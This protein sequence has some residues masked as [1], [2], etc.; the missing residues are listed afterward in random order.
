MIKEF[1]QWTGESPDEAYAIL[2]ICDKCGYE[3]WQ[4]ARTRTAVN[5]KL[6]AEGW[7]LL[8]EKHICAR[9]VEKRRK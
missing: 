5:R 4:T 9:C 2:L 8:G 3:G 6:F 7:R 1:S